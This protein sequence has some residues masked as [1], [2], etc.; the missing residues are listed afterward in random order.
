[1]RTKLRHLPARAAAGAYI[2]SSGLDKLEADDDRAKQLQVWAAEAYP[3]LAELDAPTFARGV[4]VGE[5]A[6]GSALLLPIVPSPVAGFGLGVFSAALL[7]M[8]LRTPGM[9]REH[10]LRP[11]R[12]GMALA[13]DIWML[14]IAGTLLLDGGG[15]ATRR[16][17][18]R[19]GP[20]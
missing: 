2:L 12:D 16:R 3:Q 20:A 15:W 13:K 7:G 9:R 1:M 11:T 19:A 14:G 4:A 5:V 10:G 6:L 17:R 18:R 8:Y